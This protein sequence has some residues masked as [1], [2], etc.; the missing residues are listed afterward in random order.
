VNILTAHHTAF[1]L[2]RDHSLNRLSM[3]DISSGRMVM[4]RGCMLSPGHPLSE[5]ANV[6][7][8]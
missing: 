3:D 5:K 4:L 1:Q 6:C 2:L 8:V 7:F